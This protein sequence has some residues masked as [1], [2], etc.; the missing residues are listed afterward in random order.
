MNMNTAQPIFA[1]LEKEMAR[2]QTTG[3]AVRS[4]LQS[5][6]KIL[7]NRAGLDLESII[8]QPDHAERILQ[9]HF[10]SP[11]ACLQHTRA[12]VSAIKSLGKQ[13]PHELLQH[14]SD[15]L[16]VLNKKCT[17]LRGQVETLFQTCE[18]SENTVKGYVTETMHILAKL[19]AASIHE[20]MAKPE[21]YKTEL[22]MKC[23]S[24]GTEADH[25]KKI[26]C[27]FKCNP[28]LKVQ[29]PTAY[30]SWQC[31]SSEHRA[32][33][34]QEA[35]KNAPSNARQ[36]ENFVPM[37]EWKQKLEQMKSQP[38]LSDARKRLQSSMVKVLL[39][40]AC[41]MPPKRA[42]VGGLRVFPT[43][44][45]LDEKAESPNHIV[46]D[47]ALMRVTKHKTS[48]HAAHAHGIE[49]SLSAEF[50]HV[51]E[52]SM[53]A[54][55]RTHL[56]VDSN[57]HAL[58]PQGFS[59]W[60]IRST[61]VLFDGKAPGVSLLRHAFCTYLDFNKLTGVEKDGIAARM[62]HSAKQQEMY[63]FIDLRPLHT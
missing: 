16:E 36:A 5:V 50:M 27:I 43:E 14:W 42:E 31:A 6:E 54:F 15:E 45:T 52:E 35:R 30:R 11:L 9:E 13:V 38:N 4:Q 3:S 26:M 24:P 25:I 51:L 60:V 10:K 23:E 34:L 33:Q 59:K 18:A 56:F 41:T 39:A 28:T 2:K 63:R 44:P 20:V 48:K 46:L 61:E 62:G 21:V 32:R 47:A 7:A 37:A 49:E 1:A 8:S 55:P 53:E 40:Y 57:G 12:V 19:N 58:T 17:E 22:R 29:H